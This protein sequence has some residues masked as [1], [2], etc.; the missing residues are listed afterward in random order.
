VWEIRGI[1]EQDRAEDVQDDVNREGELRALDDSRE[2]SYRAMG[3]VLDR[4]SDI[5]DSVDDV[6][7][8]AGEENIEDGHVARCGLHK[9]GPH[10][11]YDSAPELVL[12]FGALIAKPVETVDVM[13]VPDLLD[14]VSL[15][16]LD[17]EHEEGA[18][19]K[20]VRLVRDWDAGVAV[21]VPDGES[22]ESGLRDCRL[23]AAGVAR[24]GHIAPRPEHQRY[25]ILRLGRHDY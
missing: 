1:E 4:G 22:L 23:S 24:Q 17:L 8:S 2:D 19:R 6:P 20:D 7:V 3:C 11:N 16:V 9:H 10:E 5:R 25:H 13:M 12:I 14:E 15:D 18:H 21:I